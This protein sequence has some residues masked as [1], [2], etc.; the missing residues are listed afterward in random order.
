MRHNL[1]SVQ[2]PNQSGCR[3]RT[4]TSIGATTRSRMQELTIFILAA[5]SPVSALADP[6]FTNGRKFVDN[7]VKSTLTTSGGTT[8]TVL[9]KEVQNDA[10]MSAT[11]TQVLPYTPFTAAQKTAL[12]TV[13]TTA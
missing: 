3:Y 9:A 4:A 7:F 5:A 10:M 8:L 1:K 13:V 6:I 12:D 11:V 2:P